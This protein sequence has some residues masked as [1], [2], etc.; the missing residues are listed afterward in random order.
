MIAVAT[1]LQRAGDSL[2]GFLPRL[3]GSVVLLLLGLLVA[4]IAKR[5]LVR[6]LRA[7]GLDEL[8][9]R[10][11]VSTVLE[12]SGLGTSAAELVG[13]AVRITIT[14][15]VVFA[16]VSLL[17]LQ[18]L[19]PSLN[20]GVLYIPRVLAALLLVLAGVVIGAFV[21]ERIERLTRQMDLPAPLAPAGQAVVIALFGLTALAQ[22]SVQTQVLLALVAVL[23]AAV[24]FSFALAFGLGG[25]EV[26]REISSRRYLTGV[27]D[28]GQEISF[29]AV[30]G[31]IVTFDSLATVVRTEDGRTLRV[32][33]HLLVDSI[34]TVHDE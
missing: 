33:N 28:V 14:V 15:V 23:V 19:S 1:I 34:V 6:V 4:A 18:F 16:A 8:S 12:R 3:G 20:E 32:P 29:D 24:A 22:L 21:R 26:A 9:R 13:T 17:G 11:G 25:R 31:E 5:V 10:A 27:Y 30:R 2:G 7:A